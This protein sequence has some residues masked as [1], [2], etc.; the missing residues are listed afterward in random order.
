MLGDLHAGVE[1]AAWFYAA[2]HGATALCSASTTALTSCSVIA[3]WNGRLMI[4]SAVCSVT[5]S[6]RCHGANAACRWLGG[7]EGV[8]HSELGVGLF[9]AG[10]WADGGALLDPFGLGQC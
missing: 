9:S 6:G 2:G 4:S 7:D 3:G 8:A 5:G 1:E 10:R